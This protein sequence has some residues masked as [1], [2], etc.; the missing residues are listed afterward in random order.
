MAC[1]RP[2]GAYGD[3][4]NIDLVQRKLT[5]AHPSAPGKP[6]LV[7]HPKIAE[8]AVSQQ[9]GLMGVH[10]MPA[11][12]GMIFQFETP[13]ATGFYMKNTL[14]PLD[15]AFWGSNNRIVK[16][17]HMVPCKADPCP[18]YAPGQ[19]YVGA[20]EANRGVLAKHGVAIGDRVVV[21][22]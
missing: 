12:A 15:I 10:R 13:I 21:E 5:I 7:L 8:T 19:T 17:F 11:E 9:R 6:I 3:F 2:G 4:N 16:I 1:S 22:P 14:I 20:L 18:I